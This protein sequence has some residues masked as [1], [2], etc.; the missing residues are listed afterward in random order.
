MKYVVEFVPYGNI[1]C[2]RYAHAE[3]ELSRIVKPGDTIL[4]TLP[5]TVVMP[6]KVVSPGQSP[7]EA[8]AGFAVILQKAEPEGCP[9][10]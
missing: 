5:I 6:R 7:Q 8:H 3:N 9:K 10:K 2:N 4:G 1:M